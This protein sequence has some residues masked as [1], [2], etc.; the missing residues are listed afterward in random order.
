MMRR[1]LAFFS[2]LL[3]GVCA[4]A[5][6][7]T[8]QSTAFGSFM[9][10]VLGNSTTVGFSGSGVPVPTTASS[11]LP[12]GSGWTQAGNF[13]AAVAADGSIALGASSSVP[14]SMGQSVPITAT[15]KPTSAALG[16]FAGKLI[17]SLYTPIVVGTALY[18]LLKDLGFMAQ[19]TMNPANGEPLITQTVIG[20]GCTFTQQAVN[21]P[22]Q[23][24]QA[25]YGGTGYATVTASCTATVYCNGQNKGNFVGTRTTTDSTVTK[26]SDD[27]ANAIAAQ[28]GWPSNSAFPR[29]LAQGQALGVPLDLPAPTVQSST[30]KLNGPSTSQQ[31]SS[32][33][34]VNTTTTYNI[35]VAGDTIT[36]NSSNVT[37]STNPDGT[38]ST[39]TVTQSGT[40]DKSTDLCSQHPDIE[41]CS[42]VTATDTP[43]PAVPTLY[44]QRY[45]NGMQGVWTTAKTAMMATPI[46]QLT[47]Q[48]MPTNIGGGSCPKITIPLDLGLWNYGTGDLSPDCTQVWG[49]A[50]VVVLVS[51]LLLARA[52]IFGG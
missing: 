47:T 11:A 15:A 32:G 33:Q 18:D 46:G 40:P 17:K 39:S 52:L 12:V 48:L 35:T 22:A 41:A 49:F 16:K 45:P 4:Q 2:L 42:K 21:Q 23:W 8:A 38:T 28:S 13:G 9:A 27:V 36:Y 29:V 34:T 50:K 3:L 51:A 31:N 6:T 14:L 30:T 25:A 37:N 10:N 7:A 20:S 26:T 5:Q 19:P 1:A 44:T 43:L 24:C